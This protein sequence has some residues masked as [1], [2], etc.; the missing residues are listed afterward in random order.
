MTPDF[1]SDVPEALARAAHAG[2]SHVPEERA[3]QEREGYAA[4]LAADYLA[5]QKL[6]DTDEKRA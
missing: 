1:A 4:T 6:A 5:L 3:R 2:T